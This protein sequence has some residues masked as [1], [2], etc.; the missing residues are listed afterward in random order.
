MLLHRRSR[1]RRQ[2][3]QRGLPDL[4]DLLVISVESGLSLDS[5]I[6]TTAEDL[7]VVHPILTDELMVFRHEVRAGT[8]RAEA[9]RNLGKRTSEPEMRKLTSL[10]IQ[11]DRFGA[12]ISK[13]MRTQARY[14]RTRRRQS[15]EDLAHKVG[16]KLVFPI[17]FL[18]MPSMFLV[19][20][21]PAVIQLVQNF[22]RLASG[23]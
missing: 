12:S 18:I 2:A 11:A 20:A 13:V 19:T 7:A 14:V 15:A 23:M 22:G 5:A 9:L 21:G 10:L 17:F 4:L 8:S 16:I 3:V 6:T 1:A